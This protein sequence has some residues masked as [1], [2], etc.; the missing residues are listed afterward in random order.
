VPNK[1]NLSTD[2]LMNKLNSQY[3]ALQDFNLTLNALNI[4]LCVIDLAA[5]IYMCIVEP[6]VAPIFIGLT[7]FAILCAVGTIVFS[8]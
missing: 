3:D 2:D 5:N 8:G 7:A 4:V 1:D 6:P